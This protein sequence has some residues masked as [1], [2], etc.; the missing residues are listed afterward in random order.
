MPESGTK[1]HLHEIFSSN[2]EEV[3]RFI[4][5][6][7]EA[8]TPISH[9]I[10]RLTWILLEN[11]ARAPED[12][13]GWLLRAQSGEVVGC[14]CCTPQKFSFGQSTFKLMMA[15]SFYVDDTYRGSGT[16]IFLKYL[17]LGR[18]YPLF[19][20]S[21]SATVAGMWKK[22]GGYPLGDS[23]AEVIGILRWPPLLAESVYRKT[24][25][26]LL[27]QSAAVVAPRLLSAPLRLLSDS[28][29]GDLLPLS[30]PEEAAGICAAHRSDKITSCRD[31]AYLKWRYFS[32]AD[33]T[34]R[35]FVFRGQG[36]ENE[37][38]V[39]TRLHNRG[40]KQQIRALHILDIWPDPDVNSILAI[41]SCLRRE[42]H[43]QVDMLVFRCLNP[44]QQLALTA[45]GFRVRSFA[46]PIAWCMD[47]Q[48]LLPPANWYFVPADGDMFL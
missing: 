32:S 40:Y 36:K 15:N 2:L 30:S 20:S 43:R 5:R 3:A 28:L 31:A 34:T 11:P 47:K 46:A 19:V 25:S 17:Q 21:A 16:T 38:M 45:K 37:W 24:R 42:Y 29:D 27:A 6:V 9:A 8:D 23:N 18:R 44:Q 4:G 26:N 22:L 13:L 39:G 12:P 35:L 41:A 7:S 33:P 1:L 10:K 14:M 48:R